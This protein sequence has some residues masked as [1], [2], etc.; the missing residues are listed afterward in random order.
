MTV[1]AA[2]LLAACGSERPEATPARRAVAVVDEIAIE[3]S[4]ES[5]W[6]TPGGQA[7]APLPGGG[8]AVVWSL[9]DFPRRDVAMQWLRDGGQTLLPPGGRIVAGAVEDEGGAVIVP[10][11]HAGAFV[12]FERR[13]DDGAQVVVQSFDGE[14]NPRWPASGVAVAD[15]RRWEY[16]SQP[17]LVADSLGGVFA[18]FEGR[19]DAGDP[20]IR[21]IRCQHLDATGHRTW[22]SLGIDVGGSAGVKAVPRAVDDGAGGLLVFWLNLRDLGGGQPVLFEGQRFAPTGRQ[23]WGSAGRV[24]HEAL[25]AAQSYSLNDYG[26]IGDGRGGAIVVFR[27]VDRVPGNGVDL[28]AQRMSPEGSPLWGPG[29]VVAGGPRHQQH[30]A[31]LATMDGGVFV[32]AVSWGSDTAGSEIRLH[33]LTSDGG[34]L[35]PSGGVGLSNPAP[36]SSDWLTVAASDGRTL[37]VAWTHRADPDNLWAVAMLTR[38]SAEGSPLDDGLELPLSKVPGGQF[39]QA[40]AVSP[41]SGHALVVWADIRRT[42]TLAAPD[43]YGGLVRLVGVVDPAAV[44]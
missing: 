10:H 8:F 19:D 16:Q 6:L 25:F 11:P 24:V 33:R 43:I 2:G 44:P 34:Y 41:V 29:V 17:W 42:G 20:S 37:W 31:T 40:L 35:W 39:T 3:T 22:G 9:G 12:A 30:E 14:A 18:C 28:L 38:L 1:G 13:H 21:S 26:V 7:M 36:G 4:N 27:D 5:S 32:A 23:L 15:A